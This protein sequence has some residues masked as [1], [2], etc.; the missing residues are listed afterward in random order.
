LDVA[1]LGVS[2]DIYSEELLDVVESVVLFDGLAD[3]AV[4]VA[5]PSD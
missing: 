5:M 3:G 2:V 1:L 4:D